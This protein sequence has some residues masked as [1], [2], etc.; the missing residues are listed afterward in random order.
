M[1]F[2]LCP[3]FGQPFIVT[4]AF[5]TFNVYVRHTLYRNIHTRLLLRTLA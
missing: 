3:F 5:T 1:Q 4:F 2:F